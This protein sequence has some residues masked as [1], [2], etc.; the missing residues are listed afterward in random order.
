MKETIC[1]ASTFF[2]LFLVSGVHHADQQL[3][4]NKAR[5]DR[6]LIKPLVVFRA[7]DAVEQQKYLIQT[8]HRTVRRR[9]IGLEITD[10]TDSSLRDNPNLFHHLLR[11]TGFV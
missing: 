7:G 11:T 3:D 4:K 9:R 8:V 10:T 2:F 1:F 6:R 5:Y